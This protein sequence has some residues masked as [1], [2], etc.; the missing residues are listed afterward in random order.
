MPAAALLL[1]AALVTSWA[2]VPQARAEN[3]RGHVAVFGFVG[4][5]S[6][7]IFAPFGGGLEGGVRLGRSP[8]PGPVYT[9]VH[10]D[11]KIYTGSLPGPGLRPLAGVRLLARNGRV[12]PYLFGRAGPR[13]AMYPDNPIFV[14]PYGVVGYGLELPG[15]NV[16]AFYFEHGLTLFRGVFDSGCGAEDCGAVTPF[17]FTFGAR[18]SFGG[19]VGNAP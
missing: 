7:P 16:A 14:R 18:F 17:E 6:E 8:G 3:A 11:L 4:W 19:D 2:A 9:E 10:L 12:S 15:D 5:F 1:V 13:I